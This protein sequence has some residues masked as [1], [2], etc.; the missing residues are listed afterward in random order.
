[1]ISED[2]KSNVSKLQDKSV[3]D[4]KNGPQQIDVSGFKKDISP[5]INNQ[6]EPSC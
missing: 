3:N 6:T 2:D 5:N 1:M 4:S